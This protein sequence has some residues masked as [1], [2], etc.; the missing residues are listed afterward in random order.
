MAQKLP[1]GK[2]RS[3]AY[4]YDEKGIRRAKSFTS[5]SKK[6]A[7][8]LAKEF[9]RNHQRMSSKANLPLEKAIDAYI[10]M[11][12]TVLSPSTIRGYN[13]IKRNSI[14][15]IKDLPLCELDELRLQRWMNALAKKKSPKTCS[16]AWGLVSAVLRQFYPEAQHRIHLPQKEVKDVVIPQKEDID[17]LL[18]ET[19]GTPLYPAVLLGAHMGM[20]RSEIAALT[21]D[22]IDLDKKKIRVTKAIVP[23]DYGFEI[24]KPKSLAGTR[25]LDMT[26][27]VY[28]YF[29]SLD[30]SHPPISLNPESI[31]TAFRRLCAKLD[32]PFHLH[33]LR[34]YFASVCAAKG[35]PESYAAMLMG[36]SSYEMIKKVYGH[37]LDEEEKRA[38]N[39]V[40]DYFNK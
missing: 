14:E 29:S 8:Y 35:L 10:E 3:R 34:H 33:L 37:I 4:Y 38:R 22:D 12:D 11:N 24:K 9:E 32:M 27:L 18:K 13:T 7:D 16:N 26:N 31:T 39:L 6:E 1:S 28:E 40:L 19:T 15:D 2:Y 5:I 23:G 17:L 21:W 25:T 36:H 30:Q 20:R